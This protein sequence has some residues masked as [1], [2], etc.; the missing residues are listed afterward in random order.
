MVGS[1]CS[2]CLRCADQRVICTLEPL[3]LLQ[4]H[5]KRGGGGATRPGKLMHC[6][7]CRT[8]MLDRQDSTITPQHVRVLLPMI[9]QLR[10][11]WMPCQRSALQQVCWRQ[12]ANKMRWVRSTSELTCCK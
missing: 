6:M 10:T 12:Q 1:A 5:G 11:E 9:K 3:L 7:S 4:L 2:T 8:C